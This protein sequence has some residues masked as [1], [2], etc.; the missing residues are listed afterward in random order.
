MD[1]W[2]TEQPPKKNIKALLEGE[3]GEDLV[4]YFSPKKK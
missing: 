4:G 3:R 1:A 2:P